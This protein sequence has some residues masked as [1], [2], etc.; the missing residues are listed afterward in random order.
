VGDYN[1]QI[2]PEDML[3]ELDVLK[4]KHGV[5]KLL[6]LYGHGDHGGG[7][8][9]EMVN[10]ATA[11]MHDSRFPKVRFS[12]AQDYFEAIKALPASASFPVVNDELY[13]KT[14]RGTFT[15]DS[16]VKRDNRRCEI[17]LMNT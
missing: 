8:M 11:L 15:T 10:R 1:Q 14:H 2:V 6:I 3:R 17:L 5:D 13:V 9:P 4:S 16:Q 7:P 12:K